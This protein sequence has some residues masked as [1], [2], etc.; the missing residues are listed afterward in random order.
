LN[1]IKRGRSVQ[2]TTRYLGIPD[3]S[4][5]NRV[6]AYRRVGV[7][8]CRR[9]RVALPRARRCSARR[10][11]FAVSG[12]STHAIFGTA[13]LCQLFHLFSPSR[14]LLTCNA[15]RAGAQP[16]RVT[17]A[18]TPHTPIRRYA[19]TPIRRFVS[20]DAS[21]NCP[22]EHGTFGCFEAAQKYLV[23]LHGERLPE[24]DGRGIIPPDGGEP[25]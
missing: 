12:H 4:R 19:D 21:L 11:H 18:D 16:Y 5:R 20:P 6:G 3:L 15:G 2:F 9:G 25:T 7:S 8:A 13:A 10:K 24:S 1:V 23:C 17:R 14:V 22:D